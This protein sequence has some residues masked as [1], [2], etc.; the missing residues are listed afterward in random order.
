MNTAP[1][2]KQGTDRWKKLAIIGAILA[3]LFVVL[4]MILL[5][6]EQTLISLIL[7]IIAAGSVILALT[8][9]ILSRMNPVN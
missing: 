3:A 6:C 2:Q 8:G 1:N 4:G 9:I 7:L 5:I